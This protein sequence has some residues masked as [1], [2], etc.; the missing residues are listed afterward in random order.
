MEALGSIPNIKTISPSGQIRGPGRLPPFRTIYSL[1]PGGTLLSPNPAPLQ[2]GSQVRPWEPLGS[3]LHFRKAAGGPSP[4][5]GPPHPWEGL[6]WMS[7]VLSPGLDRCP[8]AWIG[9]ESEFTVS[10]ESHDPRLRPHAPPQTTLP[11]RR[12]QITTSA[13]SSLD[14]G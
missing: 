12:R 3:C 5:T 7:M 2:V 14:A 1:L 9:M 10:S 8:L 11:L 6:P 4:P 13:A